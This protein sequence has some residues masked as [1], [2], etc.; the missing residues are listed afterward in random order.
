MREMHDAPIQGLE[1]EDVVR[2]IEYATW[3][4]D[5]YEIVEDFEVAKFTCQGLIS[6]ALD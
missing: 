3:R 6:N 4:L 5:Q 1:G 2:W